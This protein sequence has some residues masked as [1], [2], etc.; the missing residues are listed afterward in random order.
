MSAPYV[1]VVVPTCGRADLLARCLEALENQTLPRGR[2]EIIVAD[3][4]ELRSGP[5][6]ASN[7]GWRKACAPIGAFTDDDPVPPHDWLERS[8]EVIKS[9]V[10]AASRAIVMPIPAAP[11]PS[12]R[13]AQG[14]ERS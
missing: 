5:A 4:S 6:A 12:E 7:R 1:S 9:D 11:T 3:D 8:L 2:Y 10:D 14:L 13:D